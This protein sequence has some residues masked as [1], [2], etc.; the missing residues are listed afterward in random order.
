MSLV[1]SWQNWALSKRRQEDVLKAPLFQVPNSEDLAA[2][3]A[4][5]EQD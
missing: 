5:V 2:K 3:L 4:K 1:V